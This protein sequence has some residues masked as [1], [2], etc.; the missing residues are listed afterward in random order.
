MI[1]LEDRQAANRAAAT[2]MLHE[3]LYSRHMPFEAKAAIMLD[4]IAS[5]ATDA[6]AEDMGNR[7]GRIPGERIRGI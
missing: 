3:A 1:K 2:K 4:Y 5:Q 7:I 6:Q